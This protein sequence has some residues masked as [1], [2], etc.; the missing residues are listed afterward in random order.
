MKKFFSKLGLLAVMLLIPV[1]PLSAASSIS[2]SNSVHVSREEI[3]DGNLYAVSDNVNIEGTISGDLIVMS[4]NLVV[5]GQVEGD[6]IA[7]SQ[8]ISISGEVGGNIRVAG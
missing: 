6:I 8:D 7:L 3:V 1:F 5:N 4:K 2:D